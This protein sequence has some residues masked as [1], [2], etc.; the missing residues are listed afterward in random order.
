MLRWD[1][2][3]HVNKETF[4]INFNEQIRE[5]AKMRDEISEGMKIVAQQSSSV[6]WPFQKFRQSSFCAFSKISL[7]NCWNRFFWK[8][9]NSIGFLLITKN[10]IF[11][12]KNKALRA[13]QAVL[14]IWVNVICNRCTAELSFGKQRRGV[15]WMTLFATRRRRLSR[16]DWVASRNP[17]HVWRENC[18]K[19][20]ATGSDVDWHG[21]VREVQRELGQRKTW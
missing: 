10:I 15:A 21:V 14:S 5:K 17:V 13:S 18:P 20:S 11:F 1:N 4:A 9:K 3:S 6:S 2:H 7:T 19:T 8:F 12:F 16:V